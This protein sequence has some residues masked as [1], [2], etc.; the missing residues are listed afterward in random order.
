MSAPLPRPPDNDCRSSQSLNV[1]KGPNT[2]QIPA[3][4]IRRKI[5][6]QVSGSKSRG[7]NKESIRA[8]QLEG[9]LRVCGLSGLGANDTCSTAHT[10][11]FTNRR[12][13]SCFSSVSISFQV[14][15][16]TCSGLSLGDLAADIISRQ[17]TPSPLR[18]GLVKHSMG[19]G[20]PRPVHQANNSMTLPVTE[21]PKR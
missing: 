15:Y 4:S 21:P 8:Y 2:T 19:G 12:A 9:W 20:D 3:A 14:P 11:D 5:Q 17:D 1:P 10:S 7:S 6:P 18:R 16:G 13:R